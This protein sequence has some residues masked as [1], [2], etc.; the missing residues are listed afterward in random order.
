MACHA[1]LDLFVS[2]VNCVFVLC[3]VVCKPYNAALNVTKEFVV[4]FFNAS[5]VFTLCILFFPFFLHANALPKVELGIGVGAQYLADYRGADEYHASGLPFPIFYY[6]GEKIKVDRSGV[7]GELLREKGWE[8]NVSGEVALNGGSDDNRAREGMPELDSA[9]ELG[10]SLNIALDGNIDDDGW[11]LRFPMRAVI[12][13]SSEGFDYIGYVFNPKLTYLVD[14]GPYDWRWS[15][16]FGALWGS[17]KFHDYYY[18]IDQ[19]FVRDDRPFYDASQGFSGVYF[20]STLTKRT[21]NWHYGVSLR[22]DNLA[23]ASF[24]DSAL[25][26]SDNYFSVSFLLARYFWRSDD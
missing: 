22:Y 7:R 25:V 11:M 9:F 16:S 13:A 18:Q 15:T 4:M 20:K 6:R 17:E 26:K 19:A 8:I 5:K 10:P 21:G 14:R 24:R 1:I 12:T 3:N 2:T 23:N